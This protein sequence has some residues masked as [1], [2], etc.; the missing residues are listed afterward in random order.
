MSISPGLS[1]FRLTYQLCPII[2]TGGVADAIPGGMLPIVSLSNALNFTTGLLSGGGDLN[3]DSFFANFMPIPGSTL[4]DNAIGNYP[5]ANQAVAANAIIA[6]PLKIS[7]LM[8]CPAQ[9]ELGYASKLGT[10]L[11]V[12]SSLQQHNS[13]GGTYTVMTPAYVYDSVIMVGIHDVSS[14]ATKQVQITYQLDFVKPLVT[15]AAAAAAQN[16]MMSAISAGTPTDGSLSGLGSTV[17]APST[18]AAPSVVGSANA[19]GGA[20]ITSGNPNFTAQ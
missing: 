2:L 9:S 13:S 7:M 3:E 1:A 4:V 16:A 17:G 8:I 14:A 10:M 12:V 18:L 6:Q 15:L 20:G 19:T 11:G 5:F